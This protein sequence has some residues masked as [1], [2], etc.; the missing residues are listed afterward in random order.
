MKHFRIDKIKILKED[1]YL[2]GLKKEL[3]EGQVVEHE[4]VS[5]PSEARVRVSESRDGNYLL[6]QS[7]VVDETQIDSNTSA[8]DL[9]QIIVDAH[10]KNSNLLMLAKKEKIKA[11][12]DVMN[13]EIYAKAAEIFETNDREAA[14]AWE[15]SWSMRANNPAEYVA[16]GFMV[17]H[18]TS[19]FQ[20]PGEPLDTT[21]KVS[22]YYTELIMERVIPFDKF[23]EQKV[24][25]YLV[26]KAQ[27]EAQ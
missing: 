25:E 1:F 19:S 21:Q 9:A 13:S 22:D 10:N 12:H 3:G 23:K 17:I 6:V 16:S 11:A 7:A 24:L 4:G 8:T 27:I 26:K 18:K 2:P 14:S 5:E 15:R 20:T